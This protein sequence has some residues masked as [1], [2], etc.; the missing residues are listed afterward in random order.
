MAGTVMR[1]SFHAS[2]RHAAALP[3][4]PAPAALPA[5]FPARRQSAVSAKRVARSLHSPVLA[6][7]AAVAERPTVSFAQQTPEAVAKENIATQK[8][9][10]GACSC[11][12]CVKQEPHESYSVHVR[13][14]LLEGTWA[15]LGVVIL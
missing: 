4:A 10:V 2:E 13:R 3:V 15:R 8:P 6:A 5:P 11:S 14:E 12:K 7:S 9:T 1:P